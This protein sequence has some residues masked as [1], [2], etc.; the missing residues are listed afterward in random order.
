MIVPTMRTVPSVSQIA[1]LLDH[2]VL[3]HTVLDHTG[4]RPGAPTFGRTPALSQASA[5]VG[6]RSRQR[7][8][9]G[10]K[11]GARCLYT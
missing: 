7:R 8:S 3:D 1:A 9:C 6:A 2:T 4:G 11:P 5:R 10:I